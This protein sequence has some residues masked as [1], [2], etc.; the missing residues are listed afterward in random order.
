MEFPLLAQRGNILIESEM[1]NGT[2]V[3]EEQHKI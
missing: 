1:I 3:L 2:K